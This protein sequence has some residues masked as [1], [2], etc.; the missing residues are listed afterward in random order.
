[1]LN[2]LKESTDRQLKKIRKIV[3]EQNENINKERNYIKKKS[4]GEEHNN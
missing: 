4:G 3:D 2:V 1:M